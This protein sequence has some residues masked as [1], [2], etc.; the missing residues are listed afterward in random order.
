VK[1]CKFTDLSERTRDNKTRKD[2][3][4]VPSSKWA[5]TNRYKKKT[6]NLRLDLMKEKEKNQEL[7][8]K[9]DRTNE[10]AKKKGKILIPIEIVYYAIK[11][12]HQA[13]EKVAYINFEDNDFLSLELYDQTYS[14]DASRV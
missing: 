11:F 8:K 2:E 9:L 1:D 13:G 5:N 10:E 12:L 4:C 3:K 14:Y 6:F 7:L